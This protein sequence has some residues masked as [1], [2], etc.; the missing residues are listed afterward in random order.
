MTSRRRCARLSAFATSLLVVA[1]SLHAAEELDRDDSPYAEIRVVDKDTGHGVPLVELET[2]NG[3]LF[4]TDNAGRVAFR[5]PGLMGRAVF[6]HVRS[7]GYSVPKDGFGYSGVRVTP[8]AGE[9]ATIRVERQN[10]AERLCRLTGEGLYRDSV[11]LGHDV[12]LRDSLTPGLVAGQDTVQAVFFR[13]KVYWFWGDTNRMSY[14]LGLFRVAGATTPL[15]DEASQNFDLRSGIPFDYFVDESGFARPMMPLPERPEGVIWIESVFV[16]PDSQGRQRLVGHYTR[17]KS[18]E[19]ELEQ[20]IAI[21][22]VESAVFEVARQLPPDEHWRRP[23]YQP[24]TIDRDGEPW[25]LFGAPSLN[26][27]VPATLDA[28]LD[29]S[30]Y[31]A[32]T[33]RSDDDPSEPELSKEGKPLWRWQQDLPPVDARDEAL[34]V[35]DGVIELDDARF[36]PQAVDADEHFVGLHRGTVQWNEHRQRWIMIAQQIGGQPSF[37]GEIWYAE[38]R[39]PHGPFRHAVRIVTHDKQTFYNPCHHP[40]LDTAGGRYIHFEGTYCNTFS[41]NPHKTPRYDYNQILYRLD[42]DDPRLKSA[43]VE[44][45]TDSGDHVGQ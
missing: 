9:V 33:C 14:P 11:L 44:T 31:E 29:S 12:P 38:S 3:L 43:F 22:N 4:V 39:E 13:D 36:V 2:V 25:L 20:G 21:Y 27:R 45:A 34:W 16:V 35:R 5:E 15:F 24:A 42:L 8:R 19:A 10:V 7:H 26:V 41:G 40:F 37:A 32:F 6:F 18:L 30:Q 28:V 1:G 23:K 17:R